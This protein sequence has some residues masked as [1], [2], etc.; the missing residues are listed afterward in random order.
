MSSSMVRDSRDGFGRL[1]KD[2]RKRKPPQDHATRSKVMWGKL[3]GI[4]AESDPL[5]DQAHPETSRQPALS[6]APTN[7]QPPRPLPAQQGG[8]AGTRCSRLQ[9]VAK[10][11]LCNAP[12]DQFHSSIVNLPQ[13]KF[14]LLLPRFCRP[15][16]DGRVQALNQ[17]IDQRETR[18][19]GQRQSVAKQFCRMA[20]HDSI[21]SLRALVAGQ[22][23][24]KGLPPIK[25][26]CLRQ[27]PRSGR[28]VASL[29]RLSRKLHHY[30]NSKLHQYRNAQPHHSSVLRIG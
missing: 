11:P 14:D 26:A 27:R 6:V 17:G 15:F 9:P 12:G 23:G 22:N 20:L 16:I 8:F 3:L 19:R 7:R 10:A 29:D 24:R 28:I 30:R 21:L 2:D 5:H 13:P 1:P 25:R 4:L 18:L